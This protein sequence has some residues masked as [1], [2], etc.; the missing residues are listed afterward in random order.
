MC[1]HCDKQN[2]K[3]VVYCQGCHKLLEADPERMQEAQDDLKLVCWGNNLALSISWKD[4]RTSMRGRP[5]A[6]VEYNRKAKKYLKR[7]KQNGFS[8]IYEAFTQSADMAAILTTAGTVTNAIEARQADE[9]L[10][11]NAQSAARTMPWSQRITNSSI[12]GFV[13]VIASTG[14]H[15]SD[16]GIDQQRKHKDKFAGC[17]AKCTEGHW[18]HYS[19]YEELRHCPHCGEDSHDM[20]VCH[21]C[22]PIFRVCKE[23]AEDPNCSLKTDHQSYGR[24]TESY[25]TSSRSWSTAPYA[26]SAESY[27]SSGSCSTDQT[28]NSA[29]WWTPQYTGEWK[30]D[31]SGWWHK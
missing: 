19:V 29:G 12:Q 13:P 5:T 1:G 25:S 14:G 26:R 23:C 16:E 11:K 2:I 20:G 31:D 9:H 4:N 24:T 17:R 30:R 7:A 3:G 10:A 21:Y 6:A 22:K 28:A 15:M 8:T 18:L 27:D